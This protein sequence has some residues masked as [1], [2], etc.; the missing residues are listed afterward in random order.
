MTAQEDERTLRAEVRAFLAEELPRPQR[1]GT[2]LVGGPGYMDFAPEFSRKLAA[3]GWVGMAIPPEYGG[4]GRG[5]LDRFVVIEEL[6]AAGAPL[7]AHWVADRQT[8][9]M[10]LAFGTEDQR[11]RFLPVIAAGEC[12]MALGFSESEAGSDLAA[13]R[14]RATKVDGGWQLSGTKMWTSGAH[15]NDWIAVL[16]RTAELDGDRHQGLSLL[17]ADLHAPG[18]TIRPIYFPDGGHRINEV[19]LDDVFVPDDLVLGEPGSGWDLMNSELSHERAGPERFLAVWPLFEAYL[20]QSRKNLAGNESRIGGIGSRFWALRQLAL[21]VARGIEQEQVSPLSVSILKDLGT[22]FQQET[23]AELQVIVEQDP[24]PASG[25]VFD[26]LLARA[27][28]MGPSW[29]ITGGTTE[30]LRSVAARGLRSGSG[31]VAPGHGSFEETVERLFSELSGPENR[32]Q[33][34][35]SGW[36]PEAWD[37]V[38]AAGFQWVGVSESAG[39]SGGELADAAS[40]VRLAGRH[41][42]GLPLAETT[43]LGGWLLDKAGL[44]V[45]AGPVTLAPTSS[46]DDLGIGP[47]NTVT[48]RLERVPWAARAELVI[49]TVSTSDGPAVVVL[50]PRTATIRPGGNV[51]GEPRETLVFEQVALSGDQIVLVDPDVLAELELRGGLSRALLIAGAL[52]AVCDLTV[53][54]VNQREQFGRELIRFQAVS[55]RLVQLAA[56]AELT[57]L[58]AVAAARRLGEVGTAAAFEVA[59]AKT[60]AARAASVVAAHAHQIH[61]AMGMTREYPLHHFTRRLWSWRQEWG[62]GEHWARRAGE[63]MTATPVDR[64]YPLITTGSI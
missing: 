46:T 11:R 61:A 33:A 17:I 19:F 9:P 10:L 57:S 41:A 22:T 30:V 60:T 31:R 38:S 37:A 2:G 42:V 25:D 35:Q 34:E 44:R 56:E 62:T 6:L 1:Y 47:G 51:A 40:L 24:D 52:E 4:Q 55:Q 23:V 28:V 27:L 12:Y 5:N 45:P 15:T 48:G 32:E 8:A 20:S 21:A 29:T 49:G 18:V 39:G 50:D 53:A 59:A 58:A 3:K 7:L 43:M 64:L 26:A 13:V 14:C 36:A 63:I 54:Y 16:C